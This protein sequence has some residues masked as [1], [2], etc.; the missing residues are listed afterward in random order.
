[1]VE[2]LVKLLVERLKLYESK[3]KALPERIIVYRDGVSEVYMP[4]FSQKD[5][6]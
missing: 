2:G 4:S 3:M 5:L 1:M 6:Y